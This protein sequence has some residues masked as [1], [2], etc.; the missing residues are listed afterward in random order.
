MISNPAAWQ[1]EPYFVNCEIAEV[2][3]EVRGGQG[4]V[5]PSRCQLSLLDAVGRR[6]AA[7]SADHTLLFSEH[8]YKLDAGNCDAGVLH[9]NTDVA[10]AE[11]SLKDAS[12]FGHSAPS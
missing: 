2:R 4:G 6:R 5:R 12:T 7:L 1:P 9:C 11:C 3:S 8:A 10:A